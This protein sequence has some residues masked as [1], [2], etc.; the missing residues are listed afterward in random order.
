MVQKHQQTDVI[1]VGSGP[2]GATVAKELSKKNKKVLILEW[3]NNAPLTGSLWQGLKYPSTARHG[4]RY[5]H[6]WKY[7]P[8]LCNLFPGPS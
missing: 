8:L 4:E 7:G 1:V 6:R 5:Y 3:G 2:G